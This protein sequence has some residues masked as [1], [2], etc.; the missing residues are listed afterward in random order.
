MGVIVGYKHDLVAADTL[1][2]V[3]AKLYYVQVNGQPQAVNG[4]FQL[5]VPYERD[6]TY[7]YRA[8]IKYTGEY[9]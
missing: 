5:T 2:D 3:Q 6:T 1:T 4:S 9:V 8:F 7:Y